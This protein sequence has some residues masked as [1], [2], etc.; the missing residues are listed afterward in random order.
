[1]F[2]PVPIDAGCSTLEGRKEGRKR[3][4][5][6]IQRKPSAEGRRRKKAAVRK[7]QRGRCKKRAHASYCLDDDAELD[8]CEPL[9][10]E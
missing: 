1:M 7:A 6:C 10:A 2:V 3:F 4:D 9:P 5:S 8:L